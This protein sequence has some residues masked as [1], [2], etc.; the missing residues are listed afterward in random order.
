MKIIGDTF[1]LGGFLAIDSSSVS[2]DL[3]RYRWSVP[4]E[5]SGGLNLH[6][7]YD[8]LRDVPRMCL[9]TGYEEHDQTFMEDYPYER[10]CLY[11]FDKLYFKSRALFHIDSSGRILSRASS[12]MSCSRSMG[13]SLLTVGSYC[14]TR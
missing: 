6:T 14:P 11:V 5:S 1:G 8:L 7:M 13:N 2:L 10:G 3:D 12:V 9:V 4:Q